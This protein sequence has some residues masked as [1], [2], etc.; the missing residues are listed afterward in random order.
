MLWCVNKVIHF[1][2]FRIQSF[3]ESSIYLK[4][5]SKNIIIPWIG[6]FLVIIID[7]IDSKTVA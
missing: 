2:I 6:T 7:L 1:N 3:D 4:L 5:D